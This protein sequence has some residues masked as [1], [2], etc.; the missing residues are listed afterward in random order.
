MLSYRISHVVA[1]MPCPHR[2]AC[3][4]G[5]HG[6]SLIHTAG[7]LT[8]FS[9][10]SAGQTAHTPSTDGSARGVVIAFPPL[11][12]AKPPTHQALMAAR[13]ASSSQRPGGGHDP[14]AVRGARGEEEAA[15]G[16]DDGGGVGAV[17]VAPCNPV[18]FD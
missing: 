6:P 14:G 3:P 17:S 16:E 2:Q 15:D 1:M 9:T 18:V 12:L 10:A 8:P 13:V 7:P 5:A 4:R 11:P